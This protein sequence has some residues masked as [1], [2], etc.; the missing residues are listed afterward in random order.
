MKKSNLRLLF[1]GLIP[2]DLISEGQFIET[3]FRWKV[4]KQKRKIF[5]LNTHS[6]GIA[7]NNREYLE[8]LRSSDLIYPDGW[9]PIFLAKLF[10]HSSNKRVNAADFVD[11]VLTI[12]N[13]QR[14]KLFLLGCEEKTVARTVKVI[15]QKYRKI[16]ISGF[17]H[18][19]FTRVEEKKIIS[20]IKSVRPDIVLIGMGV[21]KQELW[22]YNN[23]KLLPKSIYW[24]V[25]GL[26]YYISG[27]KSRA[28][29]WMRKIGLE[30]LYRL[31]QEPRRLWRRYTIGNLHI[32]YQLISYLINKRK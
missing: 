1:F 26:F 32:F 19:F 10:G 18:G 30:W 29:L 11:K 8:A 7:F 5:Y 14:S 22:V 6:V 3:I 12:L 25:G 16:I 4:G 15:K 2:L 13:R 27:L 20:Q 9:G 21:P 24:T 28:P 17:H 23:W 31:L